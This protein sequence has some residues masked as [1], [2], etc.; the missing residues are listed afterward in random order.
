MFFNARHQKS[1]LPMSKYASFTSKD[2]MFNF[3]CVDYPAGKVEF[4][5][6]CPF[7]YVP[8]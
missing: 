1:K 5:L 6:P 4:K 8:R 2:D 3:Y 7:P